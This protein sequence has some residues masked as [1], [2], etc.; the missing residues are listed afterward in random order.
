MGSKKR[1]GTT[2]KRWR[3]DNRTYSLERV[4]C[5]KE[6]CKC[7]RGQLHGPY[8]YA[9]WIEGGK[10][11]SQY[12]GKRLPR[13][14]KVQM[15]SGKRESDKSHAQ[16]AFFIRRRPWETDDP[17]QVRSQVLCSAFQP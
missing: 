14:V 12:I 9:Y 2:P 8:W 11:K 16:L 17:N 6:N 4:R 10:P 7:A 3:T 15:E 13:G 1:V 5:G